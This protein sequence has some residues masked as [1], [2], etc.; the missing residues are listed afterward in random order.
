MKILR[1]FPW[2]LLALLSACVTV[3]PPAPPV[4]PVLV[5]PAVP[6]PELAAP[7]LQSADWT[8]VSGW[9][10]DDPTLAWDAFMQS[11]S[12][13][14]RQPAWQ[15][16]CS[17]AAGQSLQPE[18]L[19]RFFEENFIPYQVVNP[20]SSS[21]GMITGYYEPLLN[22]SRTRSSRYRYPLY[23]TPSD[24]LVIDLSPVYPELKNMRLR[25][26]LQGNRVVPY[27]SR[28]E[29]ENG[30]APVKGNELFWVDNAVDLFFLQ[31]QGSGK[32]KLPNG[33]LMRIGYAD[34]N[35]YPYKSIGKSLVERGELTLDKASMQG[36]KDWAKRNPDKLTELLNVNAS[37]VFFRELP[38][39]LAGPL[40]AL[41][42][43]LTAGRSLAVDPRTIPL[44]APVF[45]STTWPNES[46]PLQRLMVAQDTGGAIKGAVRAD[47]F[48]GFGSD[49]GKQAGSMKQ[50]GR[51]WV[52]LPRGYPLPLV[53]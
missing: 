21:E 8:A 23:S 13:L 27:Y 14:K 34:Q 29:I 43:P 30:A 32:I 28:A 35:G 31:I 42:V 7:V 16:V 36:I 17:A 24:L 38:N 2:F 45:L 53:Q 1:I 33:E 15:A 20:D 47:F 52:L 6:P 26:R 51:M 18:T 19:R 10:E 11:C 46:K 3:P 41:G 5:T 22:G 9:S 25:G 44:G 48:W 49:A 39:Q 40:G 4:P 50:R 12:T 37:Y